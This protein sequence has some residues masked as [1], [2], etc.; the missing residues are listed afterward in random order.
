MS[1][2]IFCSLFSCIYNPGQ[3]NCLTYAVS[4]KKL[5]LTSVAV[6]LTFE[7]FLINPVFF[8]LEVKIC[9]QQ[10]SKYCRRQQN[11]LTQM[12]HL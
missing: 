12:K 10:K 8:K 5:D 2:F 7:T 4:L 1:F 11:S 3:S 6:F 9:A